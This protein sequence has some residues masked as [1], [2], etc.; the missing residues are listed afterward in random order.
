[1]QLNMQLQFWLWFC[2][3]PGESLPLQGEEVN[4]RIRVIGYPVHDPSIV[5]VQKRGIL[6]I[7]FSSG[8]RKIK[9]S[10]G[11]EISGRDYDN[12][13]NNWIFGNVK[14]NLAE[15]FRWAGYD[16]EDCSGGK[17]ALWAPDVIWNPYYKNGDGTKGP[18]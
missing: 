13:T 11:L 9:R 5:K 16:D 15:S 18:I 17:Y 3:Y 12:V 10:G 6:Y 1:M 14:E 2:W 4:Y 7:W 8:R